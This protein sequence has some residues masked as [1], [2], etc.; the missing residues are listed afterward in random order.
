MIMPSIFSSE[1]EV[2]FSCPPT[3]S[4]GSA[5]GAVILIACHWDLWT[6]KSLN[7]ITSCFSCV[8]RTHRQ[9]AAHLIK[10]DLF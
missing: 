4:Q 9:A 3:V 2:M 7:K 1:E 5:N 8:Y 6:L 10:S